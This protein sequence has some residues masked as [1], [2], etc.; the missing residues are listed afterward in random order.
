MSLV[1][2]QKVA[3]TR[4]T[5]RLLVGLLLISVTATWFFMRQGVL[6]AYGDAE[7]HLNIAKRVVHSVTPGFAQLGGIWLPLP[8]VLM[9]PFVA[10]EPLY[11]TG[12]AGSIVS[13]AAFCV[14][15][16]FIY[17]TAQ[18]L[19]NN[20]GAALVACAVFALNP[21]ILYLQSTAMTELPLIAFFTLSTYFFIK[22]IQN[23]QDLVSLLAAAFF[24]F[25]ATLTRY[26]GWFLVLFEAMSIV[27]LYGWRK[28]DWNQLQG[29]LVLFATLAFFGIALW[30]A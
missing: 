19:T 18:L 25:C 7:S 30:L 20:R 15:G 11:R 24:G 2:L 21:N 12:L 26:D 23:D 13:G 28:Q 16:V 1:P 29:K 22:F 3:K 6:L 8:H 10:I 27:L 14:S 17:K 4:A 9:L 5:S